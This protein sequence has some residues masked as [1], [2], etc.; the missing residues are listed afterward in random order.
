MDLHQKLHHELQRLERLWIKQGAP[1]VG[2]LAPGVP[3]EV[4]LEAWRD[5]DVVPPAS[6]LA[7]WSWHNGTTRP[8]W[9]GQHLDELTGFSNWCLVS[10]EQASERYREQRDNY[11]EPAPE[12]DMLHWQRSWVP[13][14]MGLWKPD[15]A[16]LNADDDRS[17]V[18][19]YRPEGWPEA[20]V[21]RAPSAG[22][23][24]RGGDQRV[25]ATA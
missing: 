4:A 20:E 13:I 22:A 25:G 11:G 15:T 5:L 17:P 24:P 21:P 14:L 7:L 9:P 23:V 3:P 6:A 2:I 8:G 19:V 10:A 16:F 12:G 1:I 18:H